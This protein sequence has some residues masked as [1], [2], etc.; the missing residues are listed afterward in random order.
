MKKTL[1]GLLAAAACTVGAMSAPLALSP[2]IDEC[3][4]DADCASGDVCHSQT[5]C[6]EWPE[7]GDE[8]CF[9]YTTCEDPADLCGDEVCGDDQ[10]CLYGSSCPLC[11]DV[12]PLGCVDEPRAECLNPEVC[13]PDEVCVNTSSCTGCDDGVEMCVPEGDPTPP[14]PLQDCFAGDDCG[15]GYFC[16][17]PDEHCSYGDPD[18]PNAPTCDAEPV[19]TCQ[20]I[21]HHAECTSDADCAA[22]EFCNAPDIACVTGC[23]DVDMDGD[24]EPDPCPP[25][26]E[27]TGF[28]ERESST[29]EC[30]SDYDCGPG[31]SCV[32]WEAEADCAFIDEDNDGENDID[33]AAG[34]VAGSTCEYGGAAECLENAD[35][36]PGGVCVLTDV[37]CPGCACLDEDGDGVCENDCPPCEPAG[38]CEYEGGQ[39]CFEDYECGQGFRCDVDASNCECI[40]EDTD[41][42]GIEEEL[43]PPCARPIGACVPDREP[44]E[45]CFAD[46][47]CGAGDYCQLPKEHCS[48]GDPDN[49]DAPVCAAIPVGTC[50]PE[51][52]G[53]CRVDADCA[54]NEVCYEE[55]VCS[56]CDDPGID[57][58]AACQTYATCQPSGQWGECATNADCAADEYCGT[59]DD[60]TTACLARDIGWDDPDQRDEDIPFWLCSSSARHADPGA[61]GL[62]LFGLIGLGFAI[63]RRRRA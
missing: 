59:L 23:E 31:G 62:A 55:T 28:C 18:D 57:C 15:D 53:D 29:F 27:P 13:G 25:C 11:T 60:G 5:S 32:F 21:P 6:V 63:R 3:A 51:P 9:T 8:V 24:G 30:E 26:P 52:I 50:R 39:E 54:S 42:D 34:F 41:G 1:L 4:T 2:P 49:P 40:F 61:P 48:Y 58:D 16:K 33:C 56:A 37:A 38:F 20:P 7:P 17:L 19:G 36:G 43:C 44:G 47:D 12:I 22:G 14:P 35:C 45:E 10:R 46:S